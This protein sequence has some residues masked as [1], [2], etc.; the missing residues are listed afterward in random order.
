MQVELEK[1]P[2][3][4]VFLLPDHFPSLW[5]ILNADTGWM[6]ELALKCTYNRASNIV[7]AYRNLRAS[8]FGTLLLEDPHTHTHTPALL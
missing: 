6:N 1:A 7:E 3:P 5:P 8:N 4:A 2:K